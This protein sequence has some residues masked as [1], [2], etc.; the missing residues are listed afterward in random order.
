MQNSKFICNCTNL[1]CLCKPGCACKSYESMPMSEMCTCCTI[2]KY[3]K[4]PGNS[5]KKMKVDKTG[6]EIQ[7]K[8][9]T[10]DGKIIKSNKINVDG[11]TGDIAEMKYD[12]INGSFLHIIRYNNDGTKKNKPDEKD[13]IPIP[14][15][16]TKQKDKNNKTIKYIQDIGNKTQELPIQHNIDCDITIKLNDNDKY[17][18]K[19]HI[20]NQYKEDAIELISMY[21]YTHKIYFK[22]E[23][24]NNCYKSIYCD[25]IYNGK[26][27]L[28]NEPLITMLNLDDKYYGHY[29]LPNGLIMIIKKDKIEFK[30]N[31]IYKDFI[32]VSLDFNSNPILI[33]KHLY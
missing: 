1:R 2:G 5:V 20:Y 28:F 16:I 19:I 30:S 29:K 12:N 33:T 14:G 7:I 9:Y 26:G 22:Y 27:E 32:Y 13:I 8:T 21:D 10:T 23:L 18:S 4:K 3:G 31:Y 25:N 11:K 6:D 24:L 17:Y 15:L